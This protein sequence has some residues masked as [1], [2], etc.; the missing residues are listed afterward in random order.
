M[1]APEY[2]AKIIRIRKRLLKCDKGYRNKLAVMS[3]IEFIERHIA[4]NNYT[5]EQMQ[6]FFERHSY[7]ILNIIPGNGCKTHERLFNEFYSIKQNQ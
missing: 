5:A 4:A 1:T 2:L 3:D 7:R 6:A